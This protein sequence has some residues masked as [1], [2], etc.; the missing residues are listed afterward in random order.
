MI[1]G[2]CPV[3]V[4]VPSAAPTLVSVQTLNSTSIKVEWLAVPEESMHGIPT[5]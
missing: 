5:R 1:I 4:I 2:G 3:F